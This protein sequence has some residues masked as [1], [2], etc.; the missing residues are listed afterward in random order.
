M[1]ARK[2]KG[3]NLDRQNQNL[4]HLT[5]WK[6]N[7]WSRPKANARKHQFKLDFYLEQKIIYQNPSKQAERDEFNTKLLKSEMFNIYFPKS[8]NTGASTGCTNMWR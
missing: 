2:T 5:R 3:L 8:L 6:T 4:V 1:G 7:H